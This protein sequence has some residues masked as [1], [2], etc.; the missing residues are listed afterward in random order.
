VGGASD[1]VY[2][3][4]AISLDHSCL[5]YH[6]TSKGASELDFWE[7]RERVSPL[8]LFTAFDGAFSLISGQQQ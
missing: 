5:S 8:P 2:R 1:H 7:R 3:T 6:R 4:S